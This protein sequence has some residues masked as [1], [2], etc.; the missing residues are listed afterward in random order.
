MSGIEADARGL[1]ISCPNCG[2]RNRMVYERLGGIFRCGKCRQELRPPAETID[3]GSGGV[4]FT[5][6]RQ[7]EAGNFI[8]LS[9]SWPVLLDET[10]LMR[11][12]VSQ[13]CSCSC[14]IEDLHNLRSERA[15]KFTRS[16]HRIFTGNA[17]LAEQVGL[18]VARML[19]LYNG[20]IP[21]QLI[22]YDLL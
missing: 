16:A 6:G 11:L 19:P 3:I 9:I 22:E 4:G 7:L 21:C 1:L 2:Q 12:I 20:R 10:C 5:I 17:A 8:Q 18:P 13:S 14:Q 15:L